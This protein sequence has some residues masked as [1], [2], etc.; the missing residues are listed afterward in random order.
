MAGKKRFGLRFRRN[1]DNLFLRL[2]G[3][4]DGSGAC[5]MENALDRLQ[6][7]PN[8]ARLTVDLGGVREFDYFGIVH[9]VK[10]LR[11]RRY[12]F[13]EICLSGLESGAERLFKRFGLA[14]G[15][16]TRFQL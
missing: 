3:K 7:V 16:V 1:K 5:Q 6:D 10:V 13:S 4:L 8:H 2:R 12:R 9:F 15:K 11:G 14:N